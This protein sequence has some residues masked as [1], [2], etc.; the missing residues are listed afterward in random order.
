VSESEGW[1]LVWMEKSHRD[2][3]K[4]LPLLER[5]LE[6]ELIGFGKRTVMSIHVSE[7]QR[8]V[9]SVGADHRVS[10]YRIFDI[11]SLFHFPSPSEVGER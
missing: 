5:Q 10:K 1:E 6:N 8:F 3:S 11:V 7:D 2:A 4:S 9:V